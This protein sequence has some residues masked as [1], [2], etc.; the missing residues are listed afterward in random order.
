MESVSVKKVQELNKRIEKINTE[1]T[2]V[3]TRTQMLKEQILSDIKAYEEQFGVSLSADTFGKIQ[4]LVAAEAKKVAEEVS[5][6]YE[7]KE[8]VVSAIEKGDIEEANQ[9]L[10]I[11]T[12]VEEEENEE[13]VV[14]EETDSTSEVD[15]E[16][17]PEEDNFDFGFGDMSIDSDEEADQEEDMGMSTVHDIDMTMDMEEEEDPFGFGEMLK[18][19]SKF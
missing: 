18:G 4:K 5:K 9:L 15:N 8:K 3:E 16:E 13:D 1:R 14:T 10:G 17:S 19:S 2:R 11:V 12:E 7:L 6:E